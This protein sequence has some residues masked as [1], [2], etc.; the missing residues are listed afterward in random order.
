MPLTRFF[1]RLGAPLGKSRWPLGGRSA[2][3]EADSTHDGIV[4]VILTNKP[5]S[6]DRLTF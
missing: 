2:T 4:R 1:E 6:S 3:N 5:K